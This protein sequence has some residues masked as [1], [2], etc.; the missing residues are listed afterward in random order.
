MFVLEQLTAAVKSG[1]F[2]TVRR[3]VEDEGLDPTVAQDVKC[4][5]RAEHEVEEGGSDG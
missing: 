1:D 5:D 2:E 3:L 4:P